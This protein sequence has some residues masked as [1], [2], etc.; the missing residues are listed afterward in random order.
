MYWGTFKQDSYSKVE[1]D[2]GCR[3]GKVRVDTTSPMLEHKGF[4][5]QQLSEI[6]HSI[7]KWIFRNLA[8]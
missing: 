7:S 1:G 8:L 2:G 4:K 6:Y 3:V 5:L